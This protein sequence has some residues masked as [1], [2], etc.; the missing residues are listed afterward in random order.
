MLQ[1]SFLVLLTLFASCGAY[2]VM[3]QTGSTGATSL[4]GAYE[5][6]SETLITTRP[7]ESTTEHA[8]SEWAGIWLFKDGHFSWSLARRKRSLSLP[9]DNEPL[10]YA[11]YAGS[12]KQDGKTL[13]LKKDVS[14]IPLHAGQ[15]VHMDYRFEDDRLILTE[16]LSPTMES[17]V[18]GKRTITLRKLK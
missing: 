8:A 12:Y 17:L 16:T 15:T 1:K 13:L 3:Q 18:E 9:R 10:T 6:V 11:S 5:L 14:F 4:E 2:N 7:S